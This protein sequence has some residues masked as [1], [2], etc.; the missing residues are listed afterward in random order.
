MIP[1]PRITVVEAW[2]GLRLIIFT[3]SCQGGE[4]LPGQCEHVTR[5]LDKAKNI[6]ACF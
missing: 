2:P 4:P 3:E 1:V 6:V 5:W